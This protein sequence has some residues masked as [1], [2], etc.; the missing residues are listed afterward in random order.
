MN[1]SNEILFHKL[2]NKIYKLLFDIYQL[3]ENYTKIKIYEKEFLNDLPI[4]IKNITF[5]RYFN[6][7]ID[8]LIKIDAENLI[9]GKDFNKDIND[10]PKSVKKIYVCED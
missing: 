8:G 6:D 7:S 1:F 3:Y 10:I 2:E 5:D 9:F 4:S